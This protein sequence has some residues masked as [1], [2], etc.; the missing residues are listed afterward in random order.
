MIVPVIMRLTWL[1]NSCV[2]IEGDLRVIIDPNYLAEPEDV[3][4][5]VLI[6]HEHNDHIDVENLREMKIKFCFL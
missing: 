6:T 4:D 1:G 5:Y 2:V 3:F